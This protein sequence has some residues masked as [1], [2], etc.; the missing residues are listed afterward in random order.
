MS[1]QLSSCLDTGDKLA[2]RQQVCE[3]WPVG[4]SI[5]KTYWRSNKKEGALDVNISEDY[6]LS[7]QP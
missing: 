2:S 4:C 7:L 5:N 3:H 1:Y 6:S